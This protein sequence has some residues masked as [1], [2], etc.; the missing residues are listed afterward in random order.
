MNEDIKQPEAGVE[1]PVD[2]AQAA[3]VSQQDSQGAETQEQGW[4]N[5]ENMDD[6]IRIIAELQVKMRDTFASFLQ[7]KDLNLRLQADFENFRKRK[8]KEANDAMRFANQDLIV[9]LLPVLDNF[10]RTLDAIEKTDNLAAIKDGIAV[11]DKSMKHTLQKIGLE[12][13][14]SKQKA[15]DPEVHEAITTVPV[16]EESQKGIVIDEIEKGY[17]LKD[18]VIRVAKVVIGE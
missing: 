4:E 13:I 2:Q 17:K 14:Q 5:P 16:A 6:A 18:R 1:L 10:D 3:E 15:F 9:Q 7:Q 11:V 12:P 8:T